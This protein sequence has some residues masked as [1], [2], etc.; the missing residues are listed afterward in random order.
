MI[1][2][3]ISHYRIIEKL[4]GGGMG[5]VYK[6]EDTRLHRFVAL[7]FLPEDSARGPQALARLQREAETVSALNHP[8]IC[9]IYD[10]EEKDGHTFLAMEFLDGVTLKHH[11]AGR[12]METDLILSLAIQIADALDAAHTEHIVHRDIKP[13]NIFVTK[14][15]HAKILD[16]GLAKVASPASSASQI[17]AKNTQSATAFAEEHLTSPGATLGT[18]AYMSPEQVRAIELDTRTDLFSFG[19]V[20]YEMAT[21]TLPFRGESQGVIFESIL[22]RAPIPLVRWNPVLPSKFED[23]V[24]KALEKDRNLRY[25]HALEMRADLQRLKRDM[26]SS[27]GAPASPAP[28]AAKEPG[29]S[30]PLAFRPAQPSESDSNRRPLEIAHVLFIDI[31]A[32]SRLPMDQQEQ[33]LFHLRDAVRATQEFDR[34]QASDQLIRLPSGD[35]MALVFLGDVEAPVRC[36]L[37][38]H[39]TLRQW[40]EIKLRMGI[41]TGPVYRVEDINAARGVAGGGINIARRVMDCG[42]AGHILISEAVADVL[43]QVS[44]WKNALHDL[45]VAEVKHGVRIH[46]FNLYTDEA[47]NRKEPQKLFQAHK[48][49]VRKRWLTG[50]AA[51]GILAALL[52]LAF[53]HRRSDAHSLVGADVVLADF[54]NKT[55]DTI[56]NDALKQGLEVELEQSPF[57]NILDNSKVSQELR[58]MGRPADA[59]LT[60]EIAREVCMRAGSKAMLLGSI[61]S[62]GSHYVIGLKAVDCE[63]GRLLG[64]EQ[65]EAQG[66][67]QVVGKLHEAATRVREKMGESLTSI[68]SFD[69]PLQATTPSLEALRS[70]RRATKAWQLSGEQG[71]AVPFLKQAIGLDPNFASA[72]ADLAVIYANLNEFGLSA[73]NAKKAYERRGGVTERERFVIDSAYYLYATDEQ[74]KAAEVYEQWKQTYPKD[75]TPY[76]NAGISDT[77]L[78]RL[79]QALQNDQEGLKRGERSAIAYSNLAYDYM[80][81][82]RLD[83]AKAVLDRAQ[84]L[85]VNDSFLPAYY[86]LA[87]LHDNA[88]EMQRCV[89][90]AMGKPGDEDSLLASQS[91]TEAFRGRLGSARV[92]S[93]SAI[94]SALNSGAKETAAGWQVSAALREA[95]FG[96]AGEAKRLASASLALASNRDLEVA[97]ALAFARAGDVARAKSEMA[98]LE[99]T[100]PRTSLL[101]AYWLPIIR[102]ATA[103]HENNP[104]QALRELEVTSLYELGGGTPPFSSGATLYS[105]YVRGQAYFATGQWTLAATE[106]QKFTQY[107]GLVWNFPLGALSSLQLARTY[108]ASGDSRA[109]A[110]YECFLALWQNADPDLTLFRQARAEY[111]NLK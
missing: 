28:P 73:E 13:A 97:A 23:I 5:V 70:F 104:A 34:A 91:D 57:L 107:R 59:P 37:E 46:L 15:G 89:A 67:E 41:H 96:N 33:V 106:F 53:L 103:M 8:N 48:L 93:R 25:Q 9:T 100:Y 55:G 85:K 52:F 20:L 32:N 11:I 30:S 22:N 81:L 84:A 43:D 77:S 54:V 86:Q 16:F 29:G 64:E 27:S 40:P 7:K 98:G 101:Q 62:I 78:G 49:E 6:A 50:L 102:A 31:L 79:N 69:V 18:V 2:E 94:N 14:R 105:T 74:E 47:G 24:T 80:F 95:E 75:L 21:G 68:Q 36:A 92:L 45:G 58:Y 60:P 17:A 90:S 3:T 83:D 39:R 1:A 38:L 35:G 110:A 26:E 88:E 99:K 87:F 72:Y 71:A 61:W 4:G 51:A 63:D 109:R 56:F 82:G 65:V 10:I 42:D 66:R 111:S 108:A 44:T 12:A 19:V 76:I